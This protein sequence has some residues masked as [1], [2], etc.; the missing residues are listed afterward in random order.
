MTK[1]RL[2]FPFCLWNDVGQSNFL[3]LMRHFKYSI[4]TIILF[5]IKFGFAVL[6]VLERARGSHLNHILILCFDVVA[7]PI[8]W[9][10]NCVCT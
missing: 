6:V 7:K 3:N 9:R 8:N 4:F 10:R 1:Y 2:S 5:L